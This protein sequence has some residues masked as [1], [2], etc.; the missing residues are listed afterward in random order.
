MKTSRITIAT[1]A[2][3]VSLLAAACSGSTTTTST[4]N[5][6]TGT[7]AREGSS[8]DKATHKQGGTVTIANVQGQTWTVP[9][10]PVQ[11][12]GQPGVARLRLRAAGLRQPAEGPE[13]RRRCWRPSYQWNADKTSIVFTIRDGVKWNDGQPFTRRRRRLHVQPDEA[14]CRRLDLYA[15]W[16]GAGLQQRHRGRQ[17]GHDDVRPGRPSRTSS[18]SPTRSAS[19]PSTSGPPARPP[20]TRTPGRTRSRSAPGRT[21]SSP[22][23]REQHPVRRQPGTTGSRASRTWRRSSTRRTWTTARPTSTWPAAR[24]SGAASSSRTSTAFYMNKSPDNHYLV[25]ADRP[26]WR[27]SRTSTRRTRRPASWRS[28]RRSRYALDR[29]A[30][31]ARSV[32]A[33][34]SRPPTRPASSRRPSR[35][36]T[37][38]PRSTAAGYDKPNPDKAK[39]L[40]AERRLLAVQP[41]QAQRHHDHRLHRLGRLAGGGQAAARAVG[42]EL[43]HPRPGRSRRTT[44]GSTT[45]TSTSPTTARPAARRRTT[46]CG[47]CCTR[48]TPRRSASRPAAT[49]SGTSTPTVDA[50]FDQYADAPTRP[51][52]SSIIKQIRRRMIK[53]VPIIPTTESVDWYQYNT[54]DIARLADAR[55]TRTPSRRRTTSRT[56]SRCC[57]TCTPKSAAERKESAV[58]VSTRS[59]WPCGTCCVDSGSSCSLSGRR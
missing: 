22:C 8:T 54:T 19:C 16:T 4:D 33:A 1:V 40:L 6:G 42:I 10:Q 32:R 53:D 37:T 52:R 51:P 47:S 49:T 25:P 21:R 9:V 45:A 43:T 56:S 55:T 41:A 29:R 20:R 38:R 11:P 14:A 28:G 39:Q 30:D 57:C 44:D 7:S 3:S 18:T 35:S 48:R 24:R 50:L 31:L 27:S 36:T 17:Q 59:W 15:L 5:N 2:L 12:G 13:P 46:S 34:S 58:R 23:T 26:T